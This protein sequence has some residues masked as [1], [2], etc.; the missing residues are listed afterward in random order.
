MPVRRIIDSNILIYFLNQSHPAHQDCS[1]YIE[2]Y[3][4]PDNCY[5]ISDCLYEI[6]HAL[7]VYYS[8]NSSVVIENLKSLLESNMQIQNLSIEEIG[9]SFEHAVQNK[10]DITDSRV[11]LLAEKLDA[12]VIVTDDRKFGK[13]IQL[14]GLLWETPIT[15]ETRKQID[16]WE[17]KHIPMKGL[18]RS[19]NSLYCYLQ[20]KD[21]DIAESFKSDLNHF[22][23]IPF[24]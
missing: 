13:F 3:D 12:P 2:K 6:Y 10:L 15:A 23:K 4:E 7:T 24:I 20:K 16:E 19:L 22:T 11:F 5:S 8:I 18:P 21:E 1:E 9:K 17:L 14:Q